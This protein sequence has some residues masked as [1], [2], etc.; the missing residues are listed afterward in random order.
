Q[1]ADDPESVTELALDTYLYPNHP[2][3]KPVSGMIRE[4][5]MLSKK[6][7]TKHYL[8][9][10]RPGNAQLAVVGKF[11]PDIVNRLEAVFVNWTD[12]PV[13]ARDAVAFPKSE[14]QQILLIDRRDLQQTQIRLAHE[15]IRRNNPD[16]IAL[17]L[18]N[19]ILGGGFSSRLMSEVRVKRG[20]TYSVSSYFDARLDEG[21][22]VISTFTRNDKVG[23]TLREILRV[24]KE[25]Q[26]NGPSE[27]EIA[28]AKALLKGQFPRTLETPESLASTLLY[29]RFY[30]VPDRYLT[31]YLNEVD[32]VS[33]QDLKR[34]INQYLK[35]DNFKILLHAPRAK[36]MPQLEGLGPVT[37][38]PPSQ[39]L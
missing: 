32:K 10:Y 36:A 14:N 33:A 16:F 12:R 8:Q 22:F 25:Y 11:S 38:A 9:Y 15:G 28:E 3:S 39:Y 17:R 1:L 31:T 7:I 18:A 23:D 4:V 13:K 2:Y 30:G 24:V 19:A 27:V 35:A 6:Q 29:L 37:V 26:Q 5:R 34:V 20:L 21:P